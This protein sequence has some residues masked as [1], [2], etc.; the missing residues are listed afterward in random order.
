[1][2]LQNPSRPSG[3]VVELI[4][5]PDAVLVV[6]SEDPGTTLAEGA[7]RGLGSQRVRLDGLSK[8]LRDQGK[9]RYVGPQKGGY[10]EIIE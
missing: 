10:R 2:P 7:V 3:L 6:L 8:K 4:K 1:M 9:L 5:T